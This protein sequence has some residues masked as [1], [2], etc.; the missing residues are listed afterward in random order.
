MHDPY[1]VRDVIYIIVMVMSLIA[2]V[3]QGC[4]YF[5]KKSSE[6]QKRQSMKAGLVMLA[7]FLFLMLSLVFG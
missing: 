2:I 1:A 3:G 4:I 6:A 7:M 5:S